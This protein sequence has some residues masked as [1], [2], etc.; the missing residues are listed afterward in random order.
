MNVVLWIRARVMSILLN[1]SVGNVK[2]SLE[3]AKTL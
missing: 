1:Q 3:L 2:E